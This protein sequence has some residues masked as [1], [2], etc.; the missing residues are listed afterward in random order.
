IE[1]AAYAHYF[2]TAHIGG[3]RGVA[4]MISVGSTAFGPL[5]LSI[6]RDV[7]DSYVP[8]VLGLASIPVAVG[9]LAALAPTPTAASVAPAGRSR[10]RT[11][12][13]PGPL[14]S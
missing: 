3:I 10:N 14:N 12:P 5:A 7:F 6:G 13:G 11:S 9:I 1:A 4:T 8:V 2:G